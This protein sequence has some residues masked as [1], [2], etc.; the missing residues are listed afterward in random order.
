MAYEDKDRKQL[1]IEDKNLGEKY[2]LQANSPYELVCLFDEV[3]KILFHIQPEEKVR[4]ISNRI[5][6]GDC[7]KLSDLSDEQIAMINDALEI[8]KEADYEGV[9]P[10][11]VISARMYKQTDGEKEQ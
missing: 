3:A 5:S 6:S 9:E 4:A 1:K 11:D 7:K 8:I 2:S 10:I